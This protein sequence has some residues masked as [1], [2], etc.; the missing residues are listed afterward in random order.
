VTAALTTVVLLS[1]PAHASPAADVAASTA[2]AAVDPGSPGGPELVLPTTASTMADFLT[3]VVQDVD[4][5]WVPVFTDDGLGEPRVT[6][7]W[8][9]PG[10]QVASSCEADGATDDNSA[11][12][13]VVDDQIVISQDFAARIWRGEVA[14]NDDPPSGRLS[15]DFS[16]AYMVAHEYAHSLQAER[17][18]INPDGSVTPRTVR[19]V[20]LHADCWA[21]VW[22]NSAY[23]EGQLEE[24]DI[25]EAIE[26]VNR[27]GDYEYTNPRHHGTPQQREAAFLQGYED[28]T[29]EGCDSFL[30]E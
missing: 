25:D 20:E 10:A 19:Q 15:G 11:F 1:T 14:A 9:A 24:G 4:D 3:Y 29:A 30:A 22:A 16:V 23:E 7:Q 12:Y 6:Y 2:P 26:T 17:G 21:G 13:C 28:G 18:W 8:P 5:Y 27:V